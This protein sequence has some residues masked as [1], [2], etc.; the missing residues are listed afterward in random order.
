MRFSTTSFTHLDDC[1]LINRYLSDYINNQSTFLT[2]SKLFIGIQ[3]R[4]PVTVSSLGKKI[5]ELVNY[6]IDEL[7]DYPNV[8]TKFQFHPI[9]SFEDKI[10]MLNST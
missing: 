10:P 8:S 2:N 1:H 9:S 3:F 6:L 4:E 7:I 5:S